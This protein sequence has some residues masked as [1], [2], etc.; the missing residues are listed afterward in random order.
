MKK[1]EELSKSSQW[2]R[3]NPERFKEFKQRYLDSPKGQLSRK[4]ESHRF[5]A[6][7][8]KRQAEER[9]IQKFIEDN[10]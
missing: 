3:L 5:W 9:K 4:N 6:K 1:F 7:F 2:R 10:L 8:A